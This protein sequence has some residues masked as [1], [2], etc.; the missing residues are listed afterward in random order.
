LYANSYLLWQSYIS[1]GFSWFIDDLEVSFWD[2][3]IVLD[4][5]IWMSFVLDTNN[6]IELE[7]LYFH[8][9]CATVFNLKNGR[10]RKNVQGMIIIFIHILSIYTHEYIPYIMPS[11][12]YVILL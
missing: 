2:K 10:Q 12:N 3:M 1:G 5:A 6:P 9:L 11:F 4:F 7:V 8:I